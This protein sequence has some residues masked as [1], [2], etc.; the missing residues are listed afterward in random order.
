[1][2]IVTASPTVLADLPAAE[3]SAIEIL[4]WRYVRSLGNVIVSENGKVMSVVADRPDIPP[5]P[6]PMRVETNGY[7]RTNI[8]GRQYGVHRLVCEAFHGAPPPRHDAAHWNGKR[9]DNRAGNLRWATRRENCLDTIRHGKSMRGE[10]SPMAVLTEVQ[11]RDIRAR[12][13]KLPRSSGGKRVKKGALAPLAAEFG[14]TM[15]CIRAVVRGYRWPH[16]SED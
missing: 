5:R 3:N 10:R 12:V 15:N 8:K 16:V 13:P 1:M 4:E 2:S 9:A 11:V 7:V 6:L 14:V